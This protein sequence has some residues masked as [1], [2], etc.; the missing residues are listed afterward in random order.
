M[1]KQKRL[2]ALGITAAM[3]AGLLS[4]CGTKA[5][6]ENLLR[7]MQKNAEK[8]ESALLNFKM[9]IAMGDGTDD[10][11]LGMDMNMETTTE[12][13]ASHGKG[14][15]SISMILDVSGILEDDIAERASNLYL[16]S[17][18]NQTEPEDYEDGEKLAGELERHG[19]FS[20]K[21]AMDEDKNGEIT[22]PQSMTLAVEYADGTVFRVSASGILSQ[23]L[24]EE[25]GE[26]RDMLL[27]GEK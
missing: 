27:S 16:F 24:P 25:Y 6:P 15:V 7:D 2:M 3:A 8:T 13:E 11:S 5:T 20:W 12:P 17:D 26:V 21:S 4:G 22:D 23:A 9:D 10:V 14:T 18:L 1:K 19:V